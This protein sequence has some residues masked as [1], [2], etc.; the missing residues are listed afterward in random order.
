MAGTATADF[1]GKKNTDI[2]TAMATA[3]SGWTTASAIT[4][5]YNSGYYPAACCCRR[6]HTTGTSAGDWY[7][8]ACGEL[9]YIIPKLAVINRIV[10]AINTAYG[11]GTAFALHTSNYYWSS[12]EYS[13]ADARYVSTN[14]GYVYYH[15]KD[16]SYGVRAFLAV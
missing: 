10:S 1:N 13:E 11:S 6:F 7:L 16:Y 12:S 14:Y 3:Q 9:G 5:S 15:S 4:N 8:P 2:I